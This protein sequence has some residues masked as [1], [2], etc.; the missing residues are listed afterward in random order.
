M[1]FCFRRGRGGLTWRPAA[2]HAKLVC[3]TSGREP[4]FD[5]DFSIG[6]EPHL[7]PLAHRAFAFVDFQMLCRVGVEPRLYRWVHIP[8]IFSRQSVNRP[9][10]SFQDCS[11]NPKKPCNFLCVNPMNITEH[12]SLSVQPQVSL[13][14]EL[15]ANG[16]SVGVRLRGVRVAR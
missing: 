5:A 9:F 13:D 3:Q 7:I 2:I 14:V 15:V 4:A 16:S 10:L 8:D 6:N 12:V 11:G 1:A